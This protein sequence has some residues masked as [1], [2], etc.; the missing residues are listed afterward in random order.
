MLYEKKVISSER[1]GVICGGQGEIRTLDTL[2]GMP[3]FECGA[4]NR[5]AT[6]PRGQEHKVTPRA[7]Q[8]VHQAAMTSPLRVVRPNHVPAEARGQHRPFPFQHQAR[9]AD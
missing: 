3:H 4:F 5:S 8:P 6:C 9:M 2:A 7:L 1:L